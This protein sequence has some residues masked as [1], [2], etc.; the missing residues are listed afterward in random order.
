M[1]LIE[2]GAALQAHDRDPMPPPL[3]LCRKAQH[4]LLHAAHLE[5][6]DQVDDAQGSRL[7]ITLG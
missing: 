5:A 2:Q 3:L 4:E 1:C 6:A 7:N